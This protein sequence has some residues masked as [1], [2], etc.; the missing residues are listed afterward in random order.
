MLHR[1]FIGM[2]S[3]H[4]R[5]KRLDEGE[6]LIGIRPRAEGHQDVQAPAA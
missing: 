5:H 6:N 3:R 1:Q 2:R 4:T